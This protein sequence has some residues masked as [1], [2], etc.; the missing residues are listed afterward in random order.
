MITGLDTSFRVAFVTKIL[1]KSDEIKNKF[2]NKLTELTCKFFK[3][4]T[5]THVKEGQMIKRPAILSKKDIKGKILSLF[6]KIVWGST[7]LKVF[8]NE[9]MEKMIGMKEVY[10]K[11]KEKMREDIEEREKHVNE[12]AARFK[13]GLP[14]GYLDKKLKDVKDF[15]KI[16]HNDLAK[17]HLNTVNNIKQEKPSKFQDIIS[18]DGN[19]WTAIRVIKS[20]DGS[21]QAIEGAICPTS[22]RALDV[23]DDLNNIYIH[24]SDDGHLSITCGIINT[25]D[26]ADQFM[27]AIGHALDKYKEKL[28][29]K[30]LRINM[31]QLNSMGSGPGVLV[32]EHA[33]VA[34]QHQMVNYINQHLEKNLREKDIAFTGKGP[35]VSHVNRCL[36]GFTQI[37]G[38]DE[39]SH[40]IN[41][42]GV[43]IQMGWFIEDL[44]KNYEKIPKKLTEKNRTIQETIA[45]LQ[46]NQGSLSIAEQYL[47]DHNSEYQ[48]I[49]EDIENTEAEI[50]KINIRISDLSV[51]HKDELSN[52]LTRRK[53]IL[54]N[55]FFFNLYQDVESKKYFDQLIEGRMTIDEMLELKPDFQK[56]LQGILDRRITVIERSAKELINE[57][58]E[59]EARNKQVNQ[60]V[61][62]YKNAISELK[63]KRESLKTDQTQGSDL[64]EKNYIKFLTEESNDKKKE[65]KALEK[66]LDAELKELAVEMNKLRKDLE[67]EGELKELHAHMKIASQLLAMQTEQA[68][69]PGFLP[70]LTPAQEL[71][72]QLLFDHVLGTVTE[73]NCKSGLDRTGFTRSLHNAIQQKLKDEPLEKVLDFL[74][75]FEDRVKEMDKEYQKS[76][77]WSDKYKAEYAFQ[78]AVFAELMGVALTITGRSSGPDGLKWHHDKKSLNPYEKNPHPLP[79]IPIF[80]QNGDQTLV[81]VIEFDKNG[82][83]MLGK[84]G[85]ALL[86]GLSSHRGG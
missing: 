83:R 37:K 63:I 76:N 4:I 49:K 35:F 48:I 8:K 58:R 40:P 12:G 46:R 60:E 22:E 71:S 54:N 21:L 65:I 14:E 52:S 30:P 25:K 3:E 42:E 15:K 41:R 82:K 73:I 38:E 24:L 68:G 80:I 23:S 17:I 11:Y 69:K 81:E 5:K 29:D 7:F 64:D 31:H 16:P 75:G 1:E 45:K 10:P 72:Y 43:A 32:S 19:G 33:L 62:V 66:Q 27:A 78:K 6:I 2:E 34:K 26:K 44:Q 85:N 13:E 79:F 39:K 86:M 47:S 51:E 61:E 18:G 70:K 55:M 9:A 56:N 59:I 36:N 77:V 57:I 20:E 28:S 50:I 53:E 74:T 67:D 84:V